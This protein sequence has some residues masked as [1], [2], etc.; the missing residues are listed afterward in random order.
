METISLFY[1]GVF[2]PFKSGNPKKDGNG[3]NVN[4]AWDTTLLER[5]GDDEYIYAME[6][7][8]MPIL[9]QFDPE[10]LL[11]SS[12]FDSAANDSLGRC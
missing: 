1:V 4:I 2:Y 11:V 10:F 12:G 6:S 3:F 9:E 7:L 8:V 5:A